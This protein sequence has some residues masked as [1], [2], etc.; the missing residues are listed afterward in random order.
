MS[1]M[2][3]SGATTRNPSSSLFDI[4]CK[5]SP[6]THAFLCISLFCQFPWFPSSLSPCYVLS[7]HL[8][9]DF[10]VDDLCILLLRRVADQKVGISLLWLVSVWKNFNMEIANRARAG[11][12][13]YRS[14]ILDVIWAGHSDFAFR[15]G[16]D[17]ENSLVLLLWWATS[18]L[19]RLWLLYW[20]ISS[21][22]CIL[23]LKNWVYSI[24]Y[25]H[26]VL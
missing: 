4:N 22:V 25:Y 21:H 14:A 24:V 8:C 3:G 9:R 19:L 23:V 15:L 11:N 10:L 13:L 17:F 2:I 18:H 20:L 6:V 7:L 12:R 1:C 26:I 16:S 5:W